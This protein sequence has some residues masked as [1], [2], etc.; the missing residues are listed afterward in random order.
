MKMN[1]VFSPLSQKINEL[2]GIDLRSLALFRIGMGTL[3]ITD[4]ILRARDLTAHYTDF[5][6][7]PRWAM[8]Q[9]CSWPEQIS[10]HLI[11][12]NV[13]GQAALFLIAGFLALCLIVG[14]QT[15]WVTFLSWVFLI[16][17]QSRNLMI[18]Y[19][20]DVLLRSLLFWS[21][22]LPLGA[23]FS[24]DKAFHP[25]PSKSPERVVSMATIAIFAQIIFVYVF[26]HLHKSGIEWSEE[27]NAV[28]YALSIDQYATPLSQ[29]LLNF[30]DLLKPLS[31]F[32][33]WFELIGPILLF[34][35]ILTGPIRTLMVFFFFAMHIGFQLTME[36]GLFPFVDIVAMTVFLPSWFWER[37]SGVTSFFQGVLSRASSFFKSRVLPL[38]I[39]RPGSVSLQ[40]S[41]RSNLLAGFFL[42]VALFVNLGTFV[43]FKYKMPDK[44]QSMCHILQL[45]QDW[46]MFSPYPLRDGGWFVI[47]GKLKD[48]T[49]VDLFN[50]GKP[51]TWDKPSLVSTTF[52][53]SRWRQYMMNLWIVTYQHHRLYYGQYL[54]RDWNSKHSGDKQLDQFEIY[55]MLE[56]TPPPDQ[57][58]D[59]PVKTAIWKHWC[60]EIPAKPET[61]SSPELLQEE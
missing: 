14:Y 17:L 44:I 32:V 53:N 6:V 29:W 58:G 9:N 30:P 18:C 19:G 40:T 61:T 3:I 37:I 7:L 1:K 55:F 16:S 51:V 20:Q 47:P 5:G 52:K 23:C 41:W 49:E 31:F 2:L 56:R 60:F 15:R 34:S 10:I 50:E 39:L 25:S 8:I 26:N 12:G 42:I 38:F 45:D 11:S 13:W 54:C 27:K 48:G 36:L 4:L 35:P 21:I 43:N 46:S 22:F 28:Y 59:P 24:I 57:K 33:Y